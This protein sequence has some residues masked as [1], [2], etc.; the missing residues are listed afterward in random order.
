MVKPSEILFGQEIFFVVVQLIKC[1]LF[2][3]QR[4]D[5]GW[6]IHLVSLIKKTKILLGKKAT[7]PQMGEKKKDNMTELRV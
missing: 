5:A 7:F 1:L 4:P 2:I 6:M 3:F